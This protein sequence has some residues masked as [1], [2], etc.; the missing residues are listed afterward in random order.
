MAQLIRKLWLLCV[1][2]LLAAVVIAIFDI[3]AL[4][5]AEKFGGGPATY[6]LGC[7]WHPEIV[8]QFSCGRSL[9][10]Q[11][12][13]VVLNLPLLF[14]YAPIFTL[15]GSPGLNTVTKIAFYVLDGI[16]ILA[17]AYPAVTFLAR[18]RAR[19]RR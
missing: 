1:W 5:I 6:V 15:G 10:Q 12:A 11:A 2:I 8:P 3:V 17:V 9:P 19:F 14:I 13:S 16:L 7:R 4:L 18:E